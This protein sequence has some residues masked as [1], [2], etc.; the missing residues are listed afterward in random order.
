MMLSISQRCSANR[1][2]M[3]A[4]SVRVLRQRRMKNLVIGCGSCDKG[5]ADAT[6][7]HDVNDVRDFKELFKFRTCN[8]DCAA[9]PS[10]IVKKRVYF[11][12]RSYVDTLCRLIHQ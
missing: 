1:C 6:N 10:L 11:R 3:V 5:L 9:T 7:T 8:H 12:L 2:V 4:Y